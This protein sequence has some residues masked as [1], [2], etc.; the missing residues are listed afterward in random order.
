MALVDSS[1]LRTAE[2]SAPDSHPAVARVERP[3][4]EEFERIQDRNR[5]VILTG[6]STRWPA[7]ER[8]SAEYLKSVAGDS[9]VT[10]HYDQDGDFTR[11]YL[12]R[13]EER[14][15]RRM[16][17]GEFL[18]LL[19]DE[20]QGHRY[21]MTEHSL[22]QVSKEL[23]EEA[24]FEDLVELRPPWEPLIFVGRHTCMPLHYH[25]TT[26]ALLCQVIGT[27]TITLFAPDQTP[28]LY[29]RRWYAQSPLFSR[30]EGRSL[31]RGEPD[32]E[33]WPR[34][35]RAEPIRFTLHPGEI[36][37][38][39][40]HWWHLTSVSGFQVS[41]T[42]FWSSRLRRW[43]FPSPGFQVIAREGLYW[44]KKGLTVGKRKRSSSYD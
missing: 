1:A 29:P 17:F 37:F 31:Q 42:T 43:T 22:R 28:F 6:V 40:V 27:K 24:H 4:R 39:P 7:H 18:D 14:D 3:S 41:L 44:M 2:G 9:E 5:P 34:L 36:L 20:E 23:A 21:Y 19:A 13:P 12:Q 38:I 16:P 35:A 15:D 8:W 11:W 26:E 32:L 30:V 25:G 33:R 10:V